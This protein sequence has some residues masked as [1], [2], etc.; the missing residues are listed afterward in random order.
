MQRNFVSA[1]MYLEGEFPGIHVD[2]ENYPPP[3]IIELFMK[4]LQAI[5]LFAMGLIVFGDVF[6]T[7][8]LRF[9]SVPAF[10]HKIKEYY[11]QMGLLVFFV[12]PQ[13]LNKYI[14]TGAFEMILDGVIVYSK[15]E[16]G[17]MPNAGELSAPL[18]AIGLLRGGK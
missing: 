9:R 8:I 7:N 18:E 3:P 13:M 1:K 17:R 16:T 5:Q 11:F 4:L 12:I 6:W 14:I 2:G 10:Y 15:L